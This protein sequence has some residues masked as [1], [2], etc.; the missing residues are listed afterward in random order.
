MKRKY[1]NYLSEYE[2]IKKKKF[3]YH[4]N[5]MNIDVQNINLINITKNNTIDNNNN[6][7]NNDIDININNDNDN[8]N[9]LVDEIA[10]INNQII[11]NTSSLKEN[12]DDGKLEFNSLIKLFNNIINN[13]GVN[14]YIQGEYTDNKI[15]EIFI[16]QYLNLM[17]Y[18]SYLFQPYLFELDIKTKY[19]NEIIDSNR[20]NNLNTIC[21]DSKYLFPT[22]KKIYNIDVDYEFETANDI[23]KR[24]CKNFTKKIFNFYEKVYNVYFNI[25]VGNVFECILSNFLLEHLNPYDIKFTKHKFNDWVNEFNKVMTNCK[26]YIFDYANVLELNNIDL[27]NKQILTNKLKKL[28]KDFIDDYD[29]LETL[30]F[31]TINNNIKILFEPMIKFYNPTNSK[32][33]I[34]TGCMDKIE[35]EIEYIFKIKNYVKLLDNNSWVKKF[36]LSTN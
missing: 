7:N 10:K 30:N 15:Q 26:K 1:D 23:N 19:I 4:V 13:L 2:D 6:N 36:S 24:I 31:D 34:R 32:L 21:F 20:N 17:I 25:V 8:D 35:N 33:F 16:A 3:D 29:N 5:N 22:W 11:K 14:Y 9:E 27:D 18:P 12:I 28:K